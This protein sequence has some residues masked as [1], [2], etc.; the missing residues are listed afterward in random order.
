MIY[1]RFHAMQVY[2]GFYR[3]R[4]AAMM[5][6]GVMR[7][8]KFQAIR[9]IQEETLFKLSNVVQFTM[10]GHSSKR[11]HHSSSSKQKREHDLNLKGPICSPFS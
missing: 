8:D 7:Y 4:D 2:H 5:E 6:L 9:T 11:S 3:R 10:I 1:D